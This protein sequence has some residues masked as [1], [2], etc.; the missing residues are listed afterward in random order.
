M[1]GYWILVALLKF[2]P[3]AIDSLAMYCYTGYLSLERIAVPSRARECSS[4]QNIIESF[5][6]ITY[7]KRVKYR[8]YLSTRALL[9]HRLSIVMRT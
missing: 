5:E 4:H 9:Q 1:N 8:L 6:N 3:R 7:C 2:R